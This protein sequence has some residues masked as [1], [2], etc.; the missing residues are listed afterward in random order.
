M[1]AV[2][3]GLADVERRLEPGEGTRGNA[4]RACPL[5]LADAQ[6]VGPP[7]AVPNVHCS[8]RWPGYDVGLATI[9]RLH[10]RTDDTE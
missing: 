8:R 7:N 10:G 4:L 1:I 6:T 9:S 3:S 2:S 5:K